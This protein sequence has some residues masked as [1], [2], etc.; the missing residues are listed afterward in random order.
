[1]FVGASAGSTGGG[2]KVVRVVILFK[3]MVAELERIYR[4]NVV[5]AVRTGKWAVDQEM[6]LQTL[7][8]F[9]AI[10]LLFLL[11]TGLLMLFERGD[12]TAAD[13]PLDITTAATAVVAT[14]NNI[15]PGLAKVGA[16]QNYAFFSAP[17]KIVMS[18]LMALGRLEVY[19]ILVLFLPRFWRQE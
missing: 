7:T 11:G 16:T 14:L 17:S 19:A 15:G 2:I 4:P 18:V 10:A 12:G 6:R 13:P 1:M 8:Y 3:T 5:R 9:I